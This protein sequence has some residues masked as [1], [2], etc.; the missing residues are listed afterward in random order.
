[1]LLPLVS[2]LLPALRKG[3]P[4]V[5]LLL[6]TFGRSLGQLVLFASTVY[7]ASFYG[8][9]AFG[10]AGIFA[11][12]VSIASQVTGLRSET[13][14]LSSRGRR[15][16]E[17][18]I[19]ISYLSNIAFLAV[20]LPSSV[21]YAVANWDS[22]YAFTLL[23][24]PLA[25]FFISINQ[26]ILP[27]QLAIAGR[28]RNYGRVAGLT[29]T[30]TAILQTLGA[31]FWPI[32]PALIFARTFGPIG[33]TLTVPGEL[34]TGL[35]GAWAIKARLQMRYLRPVLHEFLY[36]VPAAIISTL[37]FQIPVY[38]FGLLGLSSSTG[39]YWFSFNL[40]F[41]PYLIVASS[42]RPIYVR[43]VVAKIPQGDAVPFVLQTTLWAALVG[44]ITALGVAVSSWFIVTR[45]LGEEWREA[46]EFSVVLSILLAGLV[47][48]TP[49]TACSSALK[50]QRANL[51]YN[52]VQVVVRMIA[53]VLSYWI[54]Q[55]TLWS[56]AAFS[57]SA[58]AVCLLYLPVSLGLI[59]QRAQEK[60]MTNS[61]Q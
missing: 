20:L 2:K 31:W 60:K 25:A 61:E 44:V 15:S 51:I 48:Q 6:I 9:E 34:W 35:K 12:L 36:Q 28:Q 13:V 3:S 32:A 7:C 29:S 1:M 59:R 8:P 33:G 57:I 17:V 39:A 26:F 22:D 21:A 27:A 43:Q 41:L 45:F 54:T 50:L 37:A 24:A 19:S 58:L 42:F 49:I 4:A 38:F 18:F 14:A 10:V 53:L 56:V 47:V 11:S 52:V 40:I 55:S 5:D 16:S 46:A 30:A 23:F